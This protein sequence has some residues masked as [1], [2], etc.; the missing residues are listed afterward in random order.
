MVSQKTLLLIR[1]NNYLLIIRYFPFPFHYKPHSFALFILA[2]TL[3]PDI[4]TISSRGELCGHPLPTPQQTIGATDQLTD[5]PPPQ[6]ATLSFRSIARKLLIISHSAEGR[7]LSWP[8]VGWQLAQ[9]CFNFACK[10]Y[11]RLYAYGTTTR[12]PDEQTSLFTSSTI[13]RRSPVRRR[14]M[15]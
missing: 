11:H 9:G 10:W 8:E 1:S 6:S 14:K 13:K 7:R 12:W 15:L 2:E 5:I 3:C 4:H